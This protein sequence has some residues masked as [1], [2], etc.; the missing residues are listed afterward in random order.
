MKSKR[1]FG[2]ILTKVFFFYR[3]QKEMSST[4]ESTEIKQTLSKRKKSDA[5]LPFVFFRFET[6]QFE[7]FLDE[8]RNFVDFQLKENFSGEK[9]LL[10]SNL[11]ERTSV[12]KDLPIG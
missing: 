5:S 10:F 7:K 11:F 1:N 6:K 4:I 9:N 3:F 8:H 12:T 2:E